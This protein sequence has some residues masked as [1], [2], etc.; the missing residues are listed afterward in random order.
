MKITHTIKV[1]YQDGDTHEEHFINYMEACVRNS[2]IDAEEA[3]ALM[4]R[5]WK[6]LELPCYEDW[7]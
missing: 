2:G 3:P 7:K 5:V 6:K 1:E 4:W